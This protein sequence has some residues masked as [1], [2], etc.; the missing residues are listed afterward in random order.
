[1]TQTWLELL[2]AHWPV[3]AAKIR[4]H[5]PSPLQLDLHEGVAYVGVVPFRMSNVRLRHT[6]SVLGLSWFL[7][8]NVRTYVTADGVPGVYFFSLD[9]SN[10]IAVRIA[11]SW[12]QLPY[13]DAEMSLKYGPLISNSLTSRRSDQS[14][15]VHYSSRRVNCLGA[16]VAFQATYKPIAAVEQA[17]PDSLEAFLTE[18][19]CL[20]VADRSGVLCRGDIHHQPWPLQL[21]EAEIQI[22]TMGQPYGF[23]LSSEKPLLHYS[24]RL[25]TL[26]WPIQPTADNPQRRNT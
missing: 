23:D 1:M 24:S 9:A 12:Y 3:P 20:Y 11:R 5:L 25:Q 13:F 22:N 8:L 17:K 16:S 14:E 6:P 10:P 21:A 7:E 4:P 2:F 26:E 18:R 15:W 19:Y